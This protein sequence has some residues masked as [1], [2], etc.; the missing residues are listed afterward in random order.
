MALRAVRPSSGLFHSSWGLHGGTSCKHSC[1]NSCIGS[2]TE[3][4]TD[5][6]SLLT[7][8]LLKTICFAA[9]PI[10]ITENNGKFFKF[11]EPISWQLLLVLSSKTLIKLKVT[12][13]TKSYNK[14]SANYCMYKEKQQ[15]STQ[16]KMVVSFL[17]ENY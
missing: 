11:N 17:K 2:Q 9:Q 10:I 6:Y 4:L 16:K 1:C 8:L 15:V 7:S 12:T 5:H 13:Y 3:I 14:K